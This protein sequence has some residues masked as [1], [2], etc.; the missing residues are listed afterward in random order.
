MAFSFS[1]ND[2]RGRDQDQSLAAVQPRVAGSLIPG[3][4]VLSWPIGVER[5]LLTRD[6]NDAGVLGDVDLDQHEV[7]GRP[8][9]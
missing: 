8:S 4:T 1:G 6:P 5:D 2:R 7:L 9:P 3:A